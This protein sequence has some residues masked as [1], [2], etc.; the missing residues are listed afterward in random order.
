M[1]TFLTKTL[2]ALLLA[3]AAHLIAG[4]FADGTFDDYYLRFTGPQRQAL[5]LGTSRAAQGLRP[6]VM[7][8]ILHR[9]G[10]Q[11][12]LFNFAFTLGQSPYGATYLKAVRQKVDPAAADGL[13]IL[14]VDPWS[15]CDDTT[16]KPEEREDAL[17]LGRMWTF[18]GTPNY[19]YLTRYAT[20]GWGS[21]VGGPLHD[22][23]TLTLLHPDGW[24]Q[25]NAPM[26]TR[27][28]RIRSE[29]K[30][31]HYR[32][33]QLPASTPSEERFASLRETV[34]LLKPHGR[35]VLVRL[36]VSDAMLDLENDLWP[37]LSDRLT[38]LAVEQRAEFLDL[39]P[40]RG[41]C[42][43]TDGNH[44]DTLS[45]RSISERSAKY[46]TL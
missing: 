18:T 17:A 40:E 32:K 2:V 44:L 46:L 8:P 23:D 14:A 11:E 24:L 25:I 35:V 3:G 15:L 39:M 12:A 22:A 33:V 19:E 41:R 30:L 37:D 20:A 45:A 16:L 43:F 13:Y 5:I 28:V 21:F 29:R 31:E 6:D 26:D 9:D 10:K 42:S 4:L 38:A 36:P 1:R 27:S 7:N 34:A